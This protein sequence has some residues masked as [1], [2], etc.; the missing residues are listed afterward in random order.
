MVA[1]TCLPSSGSVPIAF[2]EMINWGAVDRRLWMGGV[3]VV[4]WGVAACER[5]AQYSI[6]CTSIEHLSEGTRTAPWGWQCN[7]ETCRIYHTKL[8]KWMNNC[9]ICWVFTH[10]LTKCTVQETKSQLK[11]LVRQR[12][13]EGFNSGV[14]E[15]SYPGCFLWVLLRFSEKWRSGTIN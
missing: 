8:I 3:C 14:K 11:N 6:D 2:W 13:A 9:C 10:I 1:T 4:T 12:C 7:T 5:H 15:L